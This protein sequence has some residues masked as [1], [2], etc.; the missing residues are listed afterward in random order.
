MMKNRYRAITI[1]TLATTVTLSLP[2]APTLAFTLTQNNNSSQLLQQL[3]GDTTGLSNF[4]VNL[5]GDARAFGTFE[6]DPFSLGSGLVLS[7]GSVE[8]LSQPNISDGGFSP[9]SSTP[10]DFTRL[11]G[12][13]GNPSSMNTAVFR[14]DLSTLGFDLNSISV[15]DSGSGI[16]GSGGIFSGFDLDAIKISN[17]LVDSA[18]EV[19]AL[20]GLD[21]F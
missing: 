10:L 8:N 16:G 11:N 13:T 18:E 6:D 4:S 15:G 1:L 2:N 17:I 14:S 20:A 7:T 19:N 21:I 5:V 3:L 9:G 12:L